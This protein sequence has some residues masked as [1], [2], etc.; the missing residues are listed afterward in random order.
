MYRVFVDWLLFC[1]RID[2][3]QTILNPASHI[4]LITGNSMKRLVFFAIVS[5]FALLACSS[6]EP[7]TT[8]PAAVVEDTA[9]ETVAEPDV[10]ETDDEAQPELV[11]ESAAVPED[12]EA[13]DQP[14][15]LARETPAVDTIAT[16]REWK[17]S[18]G[19]HYHRLVPTQPTVG[20]ADKVEVAEVFWYGCPHCFNF[21]SAINSW[22]KS[23]P[24]NARFIRIPAVWNPLARLHGRLYY[25]EEVLA[26]NDKLADVDA[27]HSAVFIEFHRK[28][29]RLTSEDAIQRLFERFGVSK[30]DFLNT[31]NSFEVNQKVRVADDLVRR[32]N[33]TGVPAMVVNGKYRTGASDAGSYPN[34]L[35]VVDELIERETIR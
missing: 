9:P 25:T 18:E 7:A 17:Y 31:W 21:E 22:A 3:R 20:G 32:Y 29:N 24:A 27:F 15:L 8:E 6:E 35:E 2:F 26:R 19:Q 30:D 11:E 34:L 16:P 10:A 4:A 28:A 14:I 13:E 5:S 33:V 23:V 12:E 1:L